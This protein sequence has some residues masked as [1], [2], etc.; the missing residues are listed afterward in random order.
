MDLLGMMGIDIDSVAKDAKE[1]I[2][3]MQKM[4]AKLDRILAIL[5]ELEDVENE[6]TGNTVKQLT[7]D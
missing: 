5:D 7:G 6:T 1:F 4:D 3:M 2:G